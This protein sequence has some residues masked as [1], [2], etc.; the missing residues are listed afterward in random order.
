MSR[1][2]YNTAEEIDAFDHGM[3]EAASICESRKRGRMSSD[4]VAIR[5]AVMHQRMQEHRY[6]ITPAEKSIFAEIFDGPGSIRRFIRDVSIA[7]LCLAVMWAMWVM[8]WAVWG[9]T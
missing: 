5:R 7:A 9:T 3:L 6:G 1:A 2:R 8:A 4:A